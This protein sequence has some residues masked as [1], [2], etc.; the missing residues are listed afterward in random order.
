M[1]I[2][3]HLRLFQGDRTDKLVPGIL[4]MVEAGATDPR[5]VHWFRR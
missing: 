3:Y 2:T 4:R 1:R 5:S